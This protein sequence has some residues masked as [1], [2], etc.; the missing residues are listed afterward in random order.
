MQD[1]LAEYLKRFAP[2][3]LEMQF[4]ETLKRSGPPP[5]NPGQKFWEMYGEFYRVLAQMSPDGLPHAF[6]EHFAA[7]YETASEELRDKSRK[8]SVTKVSARRSP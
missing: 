5:A 8:P 7:A 4:G 1:A 2:E 6:A 3:Q